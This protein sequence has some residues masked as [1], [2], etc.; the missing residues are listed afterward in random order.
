MLL[1]E[2]YAVLDRFLGRDELTALRPEVQARIA[3]PAGP[4]CERPHNTLVPLRWNDV[5][6]GRVLSSQRR[7]R[8]VE[9]A[10]AAG[11]LRWI[12]GY[13]SL[14]EARSPALW[15]HQDWWCWDHRVSYR[16]AAPQIA[17]LCYLTDTD[18]RNA[19]LRVLPGSHHAS[20]TLHAILPEAHAQDAGELP[21][22]HPAMSDHPDQVT[23]ELRAGDAVVMDY[24]L[25]HGTHGN[26]TDARRDCLLLTFAPSWRDLPADIRGHLIRHPALPTAG[27]RVAAAWARHVLPSH[28][29]PVADLPL[30]R[31]APE[32]FSVV[33]KRDAHVGGEAT[34][35]RRGR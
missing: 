19:A 2:G 6:V 35:G 29:G 27:E 18:E 23:L 8:R 13:L 10:A 32:D 16:V 17:M 3:A 9:Q 12:S 15:W 31:A 34:A 11:D 20:T 25:L 30:N 28:D 33:R 22:T 7:R 5:I 24:R 4:S 21:L 26:T 14:K 1:R